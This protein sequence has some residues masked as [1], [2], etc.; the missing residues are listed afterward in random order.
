MREQLICCEMGMVIGGRR[1]RSHATHSEDRIKNDLK[2][3]LFEK[4]QVVIFMDFFFFS[5]R[6]LSLVIV[7]KGSS[8]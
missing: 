2:V 3:V 6:S 7:L 8:P 4:A 1:V 5:G